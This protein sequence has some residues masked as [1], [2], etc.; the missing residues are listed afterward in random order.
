ML[1]CDFK[2]RK[3]HRIRM[4]YEDTHFVC[5]VELWVFL[6][7]KKFI[8]KLNKLFFFFKARTCLRGYR[9]FLNLAYDGQIKFCVQLW[10]V[11]NSN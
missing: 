9:T 3:K 1:A 10:V 2:S 4:I 11:N 7:Q 5:L 6:F 8:C